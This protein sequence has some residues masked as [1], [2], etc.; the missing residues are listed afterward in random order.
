MKTFFSTMAD[1]IGDFLLGYMTKIGGAI[2][3]V[4]LGAK[5][6]AGYTGA[7]IVQ[8]QT[9]VESALVAA[10]LATA[11]AGPVTAGAVST[12]ET[13]GRAGI[14]AA[15]VSVV[16]SN[17]MFTTE[18]KFA[19]FLSNAAADATA[20]SITRIVPAA[21]QVTFVLNAASTGVVAVD[22][23]L[24]MKSGELPTA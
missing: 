5:S 8:F 10:G 15:G 17:P 21:G 13:Q 14:A 20:V 24:L 2:P 18:S 11:S 1:K 19:A 7:T 9:A 3:M 6:Y 4:L 12:T 22:W 23:M 16:V